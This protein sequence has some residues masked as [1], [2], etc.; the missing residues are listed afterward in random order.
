[1]KG[2]KRNTQMPL[3]DQQNLLAWHAQVHVPKLN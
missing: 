3:F 2:I 1:M